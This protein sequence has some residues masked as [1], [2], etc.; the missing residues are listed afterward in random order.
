MPGAC[1]LHNTFLCYKTATQPPA[2][3]TTPRTVAGVLNCPVA[4]ALAACEPLELDGECFKESRI[5]PAFKM[6]NV[7][8]P[9]LE[10]FVL[11]AYGK[12][13][14]VAFP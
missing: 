13:V 5:D 10:E 7:D 12:K 6:K 14:S 1:A 11:N 3:P 4:T 2:Q 9:D 8:T